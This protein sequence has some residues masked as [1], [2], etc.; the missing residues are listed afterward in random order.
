MA[1]HNTLGKKGEELAVRFLAG[2]GY[3]ILETSWRFQHKEVDII[4]SDG[5]V[6]VFVEVKTR[7]SDYWGNPEEFVTKQ[8]QRFLIVAAEEYIMTSNFDGD[9]RFDIV[10]VIFEDAEPVIEHIIEAYYP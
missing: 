1:D 4:A 7:T 3:K 6:L 2:L 9:A 5:N 8:K 10:S